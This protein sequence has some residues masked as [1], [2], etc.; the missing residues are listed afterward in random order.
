[1]D[2]NKFVDEI[3]E[4]YGYG[5]ELKVAIKMAIPLMV[6]D[7]GDEQAVLNVFNTVRI[8]ATGDMG[9]ENR[10]K[11]EGEMLGGVISH[12]SHE[13]GDLYNNDRDPGS[14]YAYETI[15]DENL[16][17]T[18][19]L[20]W[21]VV[22]DHAND[23]QGEK[24]KETFGTTI[25]FPYFLHELGHAYAM[26]NPIYSR[27][28]NEV[29][30]KHGMVEEKNVL[31]EVDGKYVSRPVEAKGVIVEEAINELHAQKQLMSYFGVDDYKSVDE[32][33]KAIGHVTTSY[34]PVILS[35]ADSMEN[36]MDI[37]SFRK[38]NNFEVIKEFNEKSLEG[39]IAKKYL[40]DKLPYDHLESN[41][42]AIFDVTQTRYRMPIDEYAQ[43]TREL[44]VEAQV[45]LC[46]Y[47]GM[48]L[49][50]FEAIKENVLGAGT[51]KAV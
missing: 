35:L 19:E 3:S 5:E 17:V 18:G 41:M 32:K 12:V 36:V 45:P 25:N 31:V 27:E 20:R 49:E 23:Y 13:E 33:L 6:E 37:S 9:R 28:G 10:D 1:M 51:N 26:Q 47:N 50:R 48:T 11:I 24:Y 16:D 42:Y 21:L 39:D 44:M 15:Y 46:S 40:S 43:K 38:D 29:Y 14:Y 34:S 22:K 30:A 2:Y 4:K 7:Y 8:F